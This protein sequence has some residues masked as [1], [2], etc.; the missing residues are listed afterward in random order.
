MKVFNIFVLFSILCIALAWG[1]CSAGTVKV[2]QEQ[3]HESYTNEVSISGS[4]KAGVMFE[5]MSNRILPDHLYIDIGDAPNSLLKVKMISMDGRYEAEFDYQV[6]KGISGLT[7]FSLPTKLKDVISQYFP[8]QLAVLASLN[9]GGGLKKSM[10]VP[11]SW[12]MPKSKMMKI[13]LNSGASETSLKLY[14]VGGG[15][16]KE[17]CKLIQAGTPTAYDTQCV[18]ENIEEYDMYRTKVIRKNY[19]NYFKPVKLRIKSH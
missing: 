9:P 4:V 18:I 19:N 5:S 10:F 6:E 12:G 15:S 1:I 13:Y 8:D 17:R 3:F 16:K 2:A 11:A 14:L 7:R